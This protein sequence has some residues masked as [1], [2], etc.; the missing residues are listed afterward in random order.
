M[1]SPVA[2]GAFLLSFLTVL[3]ALGKG[4]PEMEGWP[5]GDPAVAA[6]AAA[7]QSLPLSEAAIWVSGCNPCNIWPSHAWWQRSH[8]QLAVLKTPSPDHAQPLFAA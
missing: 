2:E 3:R 5:P 7:G 6:W 1:N 4:C 8:L